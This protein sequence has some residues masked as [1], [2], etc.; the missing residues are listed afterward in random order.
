MMECT[1]CGRYNVSARKFK[2][3]PRC[4]KAARKYYDEKIKW[5]FPKFR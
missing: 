4:R 1:K 3:C 5:H 2:L